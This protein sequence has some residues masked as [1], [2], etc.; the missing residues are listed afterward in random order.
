M[1]N[2][3]NKNMQSSCGRRN[4]LVRAVAFATSI[5]LT[6]SSVFAYSTV[7][8]YAAEET[9]ALESSVL[10]SS[11]ES[12]DAASD[13][14]SEESSA[15]AEGSSESSFDEASAGSGSTEEVTETEEGS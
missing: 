9:A 14:S 11:E 1:G 6:V 10:D 4:G 5:S 8:S 15:A 2:Q 7:K 13:A 3:K 12:S